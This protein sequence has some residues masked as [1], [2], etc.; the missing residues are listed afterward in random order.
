MFCQRWKRS[1][2]SLDVERAERNPLPETGVEAPVDLTPRLGRPR[3]RRMI[4]LRGPRS[5]GSGVART[6]HGGSASRRRRVRAGR[7]PGRRPEPGKVPAQLPG[8]RARRREP[9]A[10]GPEREGRIVGCRQRTRQGPHAAARR[11]M[12]KLARGRPSRRK[13]RRPP[14][15]SALRAAAVGQGQMAAWAGH[16]PAAVRSGVAVDRAR[17]RRPLVEGGRHFQAH[18]SAG[19]TARCRSSHGWPGRSPAYRCRPCSARR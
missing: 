9:I 11:A 4:A 17:C 3:Q 19:S 7:S 16:G 10:R 18:E 6:A 5:Q 8:N 13:A 2:S 12:A 1:R 14:S 15:S